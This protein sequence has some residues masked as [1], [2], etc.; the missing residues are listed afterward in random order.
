LKRKYKL[1]NHQYI[2]E[3]S[4]HER[5]EEKMYIEKENEGLKD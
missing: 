2:D 5:N 1:E 4:T 3:N